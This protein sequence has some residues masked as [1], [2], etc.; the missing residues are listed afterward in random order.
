VGLVVLEAMASGLPILGSN[1]DPLIEYLRDGENSML[2]SP[3]NSDKL[4]EGIIR[5]LVD[6]E[7]RDRL[8]R[9]GRKTAE[10]F[11]WGNTALRREEF[12]RGVL[13]ERL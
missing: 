8:I 2:V 1:I 6:V 7:L 10:A 9:N 12:Y 11:S 4:V 3:L 13:A 5:I